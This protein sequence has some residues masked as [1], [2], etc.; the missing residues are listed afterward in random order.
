MDNIDR[1][2]N[3]LG[4][5]T[6]EALSAALYLMGADQGF[7]I[8]AERC[9]LLPTATREQLAPGAIVAIYGHQVTRIARVW[10]VTPTKV[11]AVYLTPTAIERGQRYNRTAVPNNITAKIADV[12]LV[13]LA[14]ETE[15]KAERESAE[16]VVCCELGPIVRRT[17]ADPRH[18]TRLA[19]TTVRT[20]LV[21]ELPAC[22]QCAATYSAVSSIEQR[23]TPI[24]GGSTLVAVE[25][26]F[27]AGMLPLAGG[28]GFLF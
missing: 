3:A 24:G 16:A 17:D 15:V 6:W 8:S 1:A 20:V 21:A 11:S 23:P 27:G 28:D 26:A 2:A 12:R 13:K 5:P 10:R 14:P 25:D 18:C 9:E 22:T 19:T 4:F 7:A